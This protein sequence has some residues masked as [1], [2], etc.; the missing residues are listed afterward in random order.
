MFV[1]IGEGSKENMVVLSLHMD[2]LNIGL[3]LDGDTFRAVA[4]RYIDERVF[5][6]VF[7]GFR[8]S[9]TDDS[10]ML[11][12]D[13]AGSTVGNSVSSLGYIRPREIGVDHS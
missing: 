9:V 11:L 7:K 1:V 5:R 4:T 8:S 3:L 10:A 6:V 12:V 2:T 13:F